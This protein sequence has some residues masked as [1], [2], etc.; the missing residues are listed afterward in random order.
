MLDQTLVVLNARNA[1]LI[2]LF[3]Y[4]E[5][6]RAC[7]LSARGCHL[8]QE[9]SSGC[10]YQT[11]PSALKCPKRFETT[12]RLACARLV[13]LRVRRRIEDE[14]ILFAFSIEIDFLIAHVGTEHTRERFGSLFAGNHHERRLRALR[15]ARCY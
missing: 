5:H 14:R 1:H 11:R 12:R 8:A 13:L 6:K 4:F 2:E 7:N 10:Y 15:K 9:R 3:S